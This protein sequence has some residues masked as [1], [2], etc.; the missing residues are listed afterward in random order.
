MKITV[1]LDASRLQG[2][3]SRLGERAADLKPLWRA[4]GRDVTEQARLQFRD[5]KDPYDVPWKALAP[6]TQAANRGRRRG[7]KPLMDTGRLRNSIAWRLLGNGVE[8]GSSVRYA[9]IHQFGGTIDH[10]AR[11]IRVR[12]RKVKLESGAHAVRF[13][14]DSHKRATTKWGEAAA[15][16]VKIPARPFI[17]VQARG[18]PRSYGEIIRDRLNDHFAPAVNS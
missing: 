2:V 14:K 16:K 6:S 4:I 11:S 7:G 9:A 10:A 3:L 8:V 13:A 12:L 18:V 5:S 15:W 17:G 1:Q